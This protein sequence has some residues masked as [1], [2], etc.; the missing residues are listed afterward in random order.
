MYSDGR[1]HH[2]TWAEEGC[3]TLWRDVVFGHEPSEQHL[4][5]LKKQALQDQMKDVAGKCSSE[6]GKKLRDALRII[7]FIAERNLPLD[8]MEPLV[9]LASALGAPNIRK[10]QVAKNA[11]YTSWDAGQ[12]FLAA[13]IDEVN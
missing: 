4:D 9:N 7:H 8:M 2:K 1:Y 5:A 13:L 6:C 10:L 12:E 11:K 3:G